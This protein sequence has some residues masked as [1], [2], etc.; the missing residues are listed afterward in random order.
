MND[1]VGLYDYYLNGLVFGD[2]YYTGPGSFTNTKKPV[3]TTCTIKKRAFTA[4]DIE[5]I[6][7]DIADGMYIPRKYLGV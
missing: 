3:Q 1:E 4:E 5:K 7:N 6:R 2:P